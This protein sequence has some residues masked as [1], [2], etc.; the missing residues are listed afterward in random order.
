[1]L[2]GARKWIYTRPR[3]TELFRLF[4]SYSVKVWLVAATVLPEFLIYLLQEVWFILNVQAQLCFPRCGTLS[5]RFRQWMWCGQLWINLLEIFVILDT[6]INWKSNC[7]ENFI[8]LD[9]TKADSWFLRAITPAVVDA[10]GRCNLPLDRLNASRDE[11]FLKKHVTKELSRCKQSLNY[12]YLSNL[13][14]P[15]SDGWEYDFI[16]NE[17][18]ERLILSYVGSLV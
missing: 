7:F 16:G 4:R 14:K 15:S 13:R 5:R 17:K 2:N 3:T 8:L 10:I 6:S 12:G 18:T 11:N 9:T 1:M